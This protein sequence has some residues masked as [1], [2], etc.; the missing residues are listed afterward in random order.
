MIVRSRA[1]GNGSSDPVV[2][3]ARRA[4]QLRNGAISRYVVLKGPISRMAKGGLREPADALLDRQICAP[5]CRIARQNWSMSAC[6][7][8]SANI[9]QFPPR[10]GFSC[11]GAQPHLHIMTGPRRG[12]VDLT[13]CSAYRL[14]GRMQ[15][16]RPSGQKRRSNTLHAVLISCR[17]NAFAALTR[18][19]PCATLTRNSST[20]RHP[21]PRFFFAGAWGPSGR[22]AFKG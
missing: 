14:A 12:P 18:R 21:E 10:R 11:G 6:W 13:I 2:G 15:F 20:Q 17:P 3:R 7:D 8:R 22:R 16:A 19:V 9:A 1:G 4:A 5:R